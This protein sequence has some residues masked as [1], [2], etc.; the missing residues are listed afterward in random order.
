MFTSIK[1]TALRIYNTHLV[2]KVLHD[3]LSHRVLWNYLYLIFYGWVC[4][5]LAIKHGDTCGNTIVVTTGGIVM[6]VFTNYV[7]SSYLEKKD[8]ISAPGNVIVY[9]VVPK[10]GE[11]LDS[12][13]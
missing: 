8:G 4:V 13:D 10:S 1:K 7:W 6:G 11:M 12:Q 2:Q 5:Y 3:L 9:P